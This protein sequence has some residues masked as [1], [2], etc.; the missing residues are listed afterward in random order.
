MKEL[1]IANE[2]VKLFDK[3]L[4]QLRKGLVIE[5]KCKTTLQSQIKQM[6]KLLMDETTQRDE[7]K[8][9]VLL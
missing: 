1:F 7:V 6:K 8:A 9:L 5:K 3:N 4:T 2:A